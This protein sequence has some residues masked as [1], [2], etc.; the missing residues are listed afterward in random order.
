MKLYNT[1]TGVKEAFTPLNTACTTIYSCGPTVYDYA[2]IGNCRAFL[3]A[4]FLRRALRYRGYTVRHI[5]NITD[6]DDKTIKK[7]AA[8]NVSLKDITDRYTKAFLED[9]ATLN[10]EP[11]DM[12]PHATEHIADMIALIEKLEHNGLTY[13]RNGSV[14][15]SITKFKSYGALAKLDMEHMQD[16]AGASYTEFDEYEKENAKDFVLWKAKKEGE[17]S[18]ESPWGE[19]R[20]GWHLECSTMAMKY[21]GETIDIHT[22]GT[23]LIF[24]HHTNEIAQSEGA[25]GKPFVR[26]WLHNEFL[27]VEGEKMSKSK[28]NF[29]TVR[30]LTDSGIKPM[31]LRYLFLATHYRK[32]LNYSTAGLHHAAAAVDRIQNFYERI[33]DILIDGTSMADITRFCTTAKTRFIEALDDDLNASEALAAVHDLITN[34]NKSITNDTIAGSDKQLILETIH[35]FNAVFGILQ[36][37][38]N[39]LDAEIEALIQERDAARKRKDFATADALRNKLAAM[40]IQIM[41][42]KHGMRWRRI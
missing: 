41:D 29:Y 4:D 19:G 8:E 32:P 36:E 37:K 30:S 35:G 22:G 24:P 14:Y 20:P 38:D 39:T 12:F 5:M 31:T 9:L 11:F 17:P 27:L 33:N 2:H 13:V 10:I 23:D 1:L 40:G 7:A 25:T 15:Y 28:G 21:L 42:S 3:C 6:V 16:G 18:W 26:Y 34:L